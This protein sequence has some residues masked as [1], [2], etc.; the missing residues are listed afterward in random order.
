MAKRRFEDDDDDY[1]DRGREAKASGGMPKWPF[2]VGGGILILLLVCG[3]GIAA[4][5]F[6]VRAMVK[7]GKEAFEASI[8]APAG[9]REVG[10]AEITQA[11]VDLKGPNKEFTLKHIAGW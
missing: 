9:T 5:F 8:P 6:G 2:F 4:I 3:G 11:L 10:D 7:S 1:G